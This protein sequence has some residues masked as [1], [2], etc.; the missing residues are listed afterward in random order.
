M[1]TPKLT[2]AV[3]CCRAVVICLISPEKY[4]LPPQNTIWGVTSAFFPRSL[5]GR[6][7]L[8]LTRLAKMGNQR[9][10][11]QR[12]TLRVCHFASMTCFRCNVYQRYL[13]QTG[14]EMEYAKPV[15]P[16]LTSIRPL[17]LF[18][19]SVDSGLLSGGTLSSEAMAASFDCTCWKNQAATPSV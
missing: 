4:V 6:N 3:C 11:F 10:D 15:R 5:P 2:F 17:F 12:I 1:R 7:S 9:S 14:R 16:Y 19:R 13:S 8:H 18:E